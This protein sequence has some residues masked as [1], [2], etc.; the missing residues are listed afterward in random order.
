MKSLQAESAGCLANLDDGVTVVFA[1]NYFSMAGFQEKRVLIEPVVVHGKSM[2]I[3]WEMF[4]E[5]TQEI[6]S[7]SGIAQEH[8]IKINDN[9]LDLNGNFLTQELTMAH[10]AN[11][12]APGFFSNR[13]VDG[14][15]GNT[16]Q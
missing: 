7:L 11:F 1:G 9:R 12:T 10:P 16:T 6:L 4:V 8:S 2:V 13:I 3:P 14:N 15:P 5:S